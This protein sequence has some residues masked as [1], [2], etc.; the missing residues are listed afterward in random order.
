MF[1]LPEESA[2]RGPDYM[3]EK[4]IP[5]LAQYDYI[6]VIALLHDVD[7][8][9]ELENNFAGANVA[10]TRAL[11]QFNIQLNVKQSLD[12]I[13]SQTRPYINFEGKLF[14]PQ[15][16]EIGEEGM[17]PIRFA[18]KCRK[19]RQD[20][21]EQKQNA[22]SMSADQIR[23]I[24][25]VLSHSF[26][27]NICESAEKSTC[28]GLG[29]EPSRLQRSASRARSQSDFSEAIHCWNWRTIRIRKDELLQNIRYV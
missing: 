14:G 2:R 4:C 19:D 22:D 3:G 7:F 27:R 8:F 1:D 20:L 15:E 12:D 10:L 24:L 21:E 23:E 28:T 17:N 9:K 25:Q 29:L 18:K 26:L 11:R 5:S 6:V 13:L 16:D